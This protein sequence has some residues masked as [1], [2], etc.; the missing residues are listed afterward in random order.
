MS[1]FGLMLVFVYVDVYVDVCKRGRGA[2]TSWN[3]MIISYAS[4]PS[5]VI[6]DQAMHQK[7]I[8]HS[9]SRISEVIFCLIFS[10]N[11]SFEFKDL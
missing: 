2:V 5:A 6:S 10:I 8:S 1:V 3:G 11:V 9:Y 7:N 4:R